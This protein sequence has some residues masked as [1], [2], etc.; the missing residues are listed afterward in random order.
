MAGYAAEASD[1]GESHFVGRRPE[2]QRLLAWADS[3]SRLAQIDGISGSGKS[4]LAEH[5]VVNLDESKTSVCYIDLR[6]PLQNDPITLLLAIADQLGRGYFSRLLDGIGEFDRK[7]ES[8]LRFPVHLAGP[9]SVNVSNNRFDGDVGDISGVK[10][11]NVQLNIPADELQHIRE[12]RVRVSTDRFSECLKALPDRRKPIIILDSLEYILKSGPGDLEP[13]AQ[14]VWTELVNPR[15]LDRIPAKFL[16]VTQRDQSAKRMS[17]DVRRGFVRVHLDSFSEDDATEYLSRND[18][19]QM[20]V[21]LKREVF[22]VTNR[23][24]LCMSLIVGLLDDDPTGAGLQLASL[25]RKATTSLVTSFLI[26]RILENVGESLAQVLY[27]SS[28][29]RRCD[30]ETLTAVFGDQATANAALGRL[31]GFTFVSRSQINTGWQLHELVRRLLL[32]SFEED[33]PLAYKEANAKLADYFGSAQTLGSAEILSNFTYHSVR[34]DQKAVVGIA[35]R[36]SRAALRARNGPMAADIW[37]SIREIRDR[38]QYSGWF[39]Y[40]GAV[41]HLLLGA[42]ADAVEKLK[43]IWLAP[44]SPTT[45]RILAASAI[46]T[47]EQRMG[48]L[49]EAAGWAD[50]A[51]RLSSTAALDQAAVASCLNDMGTIL[52]TQ[53]RLEESLDMYTRA[54]QLGSSSDTDAGSWEAAYARLY[55]GVIYTGGLGRYELAID[56][57][58]SAE[59]KFRD[60]GDDMGVVMSI[61]RQGWLARMQGDLSTALT[62]H[63]RARAGLTEDA[64]PLLVGELMHSTGNVLRQLRRWDDAREHYDKSLDLFARSNA[65]RHM[66]LL[67]K[68][69]GELLVTQGKAT[70]TEELLQAG[71]AH[72]RDCL[73]AK[74]KAGQTRETSPTLSL[75]GEA[76][77][78]LGQFEDAYVALTRALEIARTTKVPINQARALAKLAVLAIRRTPLAVPE[79]EGQAQGVIEFSANAGFHHYEADGFA[80]LSALHKREG[81]IGPASEAL[82]RSCQ[83][84]M[85]YNQYRI[86]ES[87]WIF[88]GGVFAARTSPT[89]DERAILSST[90]EALVDRLGV[91]PQDI[92]RFQDSAGMADT[93]LAA[94][95]LDRDPRG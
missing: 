21:N 33:D 93:R 72:L 64:E 68:D 12:D 73:T 3:D 26:D 60:L 32:E 57:F 59:E 23:N 46:A 8:S 14:W 87:L 11:Q 76:L 6:S 45:L 40:C 10:L 50:K 62:E 4:W 92:A 16:L 19:R 67:K 28:V 41:A 30:I 38:G 89:S 22:E 34:A 77:T 88:R 81:R 56:A 39:E 9:V 69:Y 58:R 75:L 53:I 24:P 70:A 63:E 17:E 71:I 13:L 7:I 65:Q 1:G 27:L 37:D 85:R 83:A 49:P 55:Q 2:L 66:N 95:E 52:R 29:P 94:N 74:E 44:A 18:L 80:V 5:V 90:V 42:E 35:D 15:P 20:S 78:E 47:S 48:R 91:N 43:H 31:K 79:I 36:Y 61:Q 82:L 54:H 86:Q 25:P 84:A 51:L